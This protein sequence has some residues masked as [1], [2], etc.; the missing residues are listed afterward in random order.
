MARPSWRGSADSVSDWLP[1]RSSE[2]FFASI[3]SSRARAT[4]VTKASSEDPS[5]GSGGDLGWIARGLT[6]PAFERAAFAAE[7]GRV[8]GPVRSAFGLHLIRVD[9][10]SKKLR[11]DQQREQLRSMLRQRNAQDALRQTLRDARRRALVKILK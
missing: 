2:R 5:A 6:D 4:P 10:I 7:Q 11:D 3:A 9:A 1:L 8:V